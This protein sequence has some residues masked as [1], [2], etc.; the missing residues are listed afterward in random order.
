MK[1]FSNKLKNKMK[2]EKTTKKIYCYVDET[3]QDTMGKLFIVA[4]VIADNKKDEFEKRMEKLET[5]SRKFLRKWQKSKK[6]ERLDYM[7]TVFDIIK[8]YGEL[9]FF[10]FGKGVGTNYYPL[11]TYAIAKTLHTKLGQN[12]VIYSLIVD[13]LVIKQRLILGANL[14]KLGISVAKVRGKRDQSDAILRLADALAG[15]V[16]DATEN[17]HKSK[18]LFN[19]AVK[20]RLIT[21]VN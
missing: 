21:E 7:R 14:R 4:I 5:S 10:K 6:R 3:G 12:P 11:M 16:R 15:F 18:A 2:K 8:N 20:N 9:Y 1:Q 17:D 19:K 13:A